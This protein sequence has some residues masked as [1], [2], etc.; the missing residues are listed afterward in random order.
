[1]DCVQASA[2][3]QDRLDG[4]LSESDVL[5][6][7]EHLA[8]CA[9]CGNEWHRLQ[10][11]DSL[12]ASAQ[13]VPA[14]PYL[15]MQVIAKLEKRERAQR[16]VLAFTTLALGSITLAMLLFVPTLLNFLSTAGATTALLSGG[17]ATVAQLLNLVKALGRVMPLLLDKLASPLAALGLCS[18]LMALGLSRLLSGLSQVGK[19]N[20]AI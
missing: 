10:Q 8:R 16:T 17:P 3:M 11:L 7:E 5:R 18:M 9:Q 13:M 19:F 1:M 2:I 15:R 6:L 20:N 12:F 4:L 14:P